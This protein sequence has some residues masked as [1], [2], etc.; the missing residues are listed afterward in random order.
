MSGNGHF[1]F[2]KASDD[3]QR[4]VMNEYMREHGLERF[5]ISKEQWAQRWRPPGSLVEAMRN[6]ARRKKGEDA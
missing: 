6:M 1:D 4:L 5:L 2:G 3:V